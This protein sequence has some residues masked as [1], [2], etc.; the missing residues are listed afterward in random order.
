V[1]SNFA[2]YYIKTLRAQIENVKMKIKEL[3]GNW[4]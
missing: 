3:E 2:K 4:A 1:Y